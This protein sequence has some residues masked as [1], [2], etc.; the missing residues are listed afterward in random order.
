M[1]PLLLV[2]GLYTVEILV[3][4]RGF[5]K[6]ICAQFGATFHVRDELLDMHFG[7]YHEPGVWTSREETKVATL[8][9]QEA[10][11]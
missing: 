9:T 2:A 6:L 11:A 3:R 5:Q 7:V 1:P 10:T 8:S 4:E